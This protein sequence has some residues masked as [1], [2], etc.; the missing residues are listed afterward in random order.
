MVD[1]TSKAQGQIQQIKVEEG[2]FV[3]SGQ[4]VLSRFPIVAAERLSLPQPRR[5]SRIIK[6]MALRRALLERARTG[7]VADT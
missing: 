5:R 1:I 2:D 4:V 6:A 3:R 7:D